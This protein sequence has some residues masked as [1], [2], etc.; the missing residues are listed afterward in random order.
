MDPA[1]PDP[2]P[3]KVKDS[4]LLIRSITNVWNKGGST[5]DSITE[6][7]S[8]DSANRKI[9][10]LWM[11]NGDFPA[12]D[13]VSAEFSYSQNGLLTDIT[14]T[15]EPT[16]INDE[17][18]VKEIHITYDDENII[19]RFK[20]YFYDGSIDSIYFTKTVLAAGHYRLTWIDSFLLIPDDVSRRSAVFDKKGKVIL[21]VT[22]F[23]QSNT[24][25]I[26]TDSVIY[27]LTKM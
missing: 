7:Y 23:P 5:P 10:I 15:M 25:F 13:G 6:F 16:Y 4:T 26:Q 21:N 22:E 2:V 24:T 19:K 8:Y 17:Y 20:K 3:D 14:F 9:K 11:G 27:G 12:T 1:E 18:T